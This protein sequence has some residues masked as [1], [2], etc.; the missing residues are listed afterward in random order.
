[1]K[2]KQFGGFA[3]DWFWLVLFWLFV[4]VFTLV[5][6]TNKISRNDPYLACL[7]ENSTRSVEETKQL[8]SPLVPVQPKK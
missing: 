6:Q 3:E 2:K 4:A 7:K 1:M 5:E 8:C